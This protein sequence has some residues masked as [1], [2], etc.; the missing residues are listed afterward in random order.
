MKIALPRVASLPTS[1]TAMGPFFEQ[2]DRDCPH[3]LAELRSYFY[4]DSTI[5]SPP[6]DNVTSNTNDASLRHASVHSQRRADYIQRTK[7]DFRVRCSFV[8]N[9]KWHIYVFQ[10]R[11]MGI[12]DDR[13]E[14][15]ETIKAASS[16]STPKSL[17]RMT[18]CG[19]E[20]RLQQQQQCNNKEWA[21][22]SSSNE[23]LLLISFRHHPNCYCVLRHRYVCCLSTY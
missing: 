14:V 2:Y 11:L 16:P 7:I 19:V 15:K 13:L 18:S 5:D 4:P 17:R 6:F 1:P 8:L 12:S 22:S 9:R 23:P 10:N 21:T 20:H 3:C